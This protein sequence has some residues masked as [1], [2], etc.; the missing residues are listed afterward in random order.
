MEENKQ[1]GKLLVLI[2]TRA[3]KFHPVN[4]LP[5]Q[6]IVFWILVA[7]LG[8]GWAKQSVGRSFSR[9]DLE[10]PFLLQQ[11]TLSRVQLLLYSFKRL[12]SSTSCIPIGTMVMVISFVW[13]DADI[14]A[15][16]LDSKDR[17]FVIW[18]KSKSKFSDN[19][20]G[21]NISESETENRGRYSHGSIAPF[22]RS[23]PS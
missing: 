12:A 3:N 11:K 16:Q 2:C 10:L 8:S 15:F 7:A 22:C 13:V 1:V 4:I 20:C 6:L 23:H 19:S 9:Q 14:I 5:S 18:Q 21:W 17:I